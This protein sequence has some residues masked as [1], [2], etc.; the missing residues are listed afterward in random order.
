MKPQIFGSIE[1]HK[2]TEIERMAVDANW[3]LGNITPQILDENRSW[4]GSNLV[5]AGT[6]RLFL[7]FHSYVVRTP[8]LNILIDT[9]NGNDKQRPSMPA[10]HRLD[11]PYLQRLKAIGL[12]PDDIDIVMCT[13]LHADHVGWNTKLENGR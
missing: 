8:H 1:V 2:L 6:D 5:E 3:L 12:A 4:L 10:W 9:C 11:T 7:S 13:H